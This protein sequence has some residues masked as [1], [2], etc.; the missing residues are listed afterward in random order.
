LRQ[1]IRQQNVQSSF[2]PEY[3]FLIHAKGKAGGKWGDR[4]S[5]TASVTGN[6]IIV[7]DPCP[8]RDDLPTQQ[9]VRAMLTDMGYTVVEMENHG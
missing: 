1:N 9:A 2:T 8:L 4:K 7:H 5:N 6:T 3:H